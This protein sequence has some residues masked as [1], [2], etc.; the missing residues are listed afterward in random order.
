M[1][2]ARTRSSGGAR[3]DFLTPAFAGRTAR[4][5]SVSPLVTHLYSDGADARADERCRHLAAQHSEFN[6][7]FRAKHQLRHRLWGNDNIAD[8]AN[9]LSGCLRA[10]AGHAFQFRV[11]L[12]IRKRRAALL[13]TGVFR[14]AG[15]RR[16]T[17]VV[18]LGALW[19]QHDGECRREIRK[20]GRRHDLTRLQADAHDFALQFVPDDMKPSVVQHLY[21]EKR[22]RHFAEWQAWSQVECRMMFGGFSREIM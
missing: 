11:R 3:P 1:D 13:V 16:R 10:A 18:T 19:I 8:V 17:A 12:F 2:E 21:W 20:D 14:W 9:V 4:F 7:V 6:T 22:R 15:V 5:E